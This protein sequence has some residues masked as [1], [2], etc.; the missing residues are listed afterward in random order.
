MTVPV[1]VFPNALRIMLDLLRGHESLPTALTA[2]LPDGILG[3][4]ICVRLPD[5][6]PAGCP[7]LQVALITG[8]ARLVPLRLAQA[9]IDLSIYHPDLFTCSDLAAQ[10]TAIALSLEQRRTAEGG[11]TRVHL[12][13]DPFPLQDPDTALERYLIPL[14]VTY[15][16]N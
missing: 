5:Q 8:G 4:R 7:Y 2:P 16:P 3:Q 1:V 6:F 9:K 14:V 12:G 15:R 13:G 11:F 10:V